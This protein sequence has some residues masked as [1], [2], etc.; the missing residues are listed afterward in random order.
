MEKAPFRRLD[1]QMMKERKAYDAESMVLILLHAELICS[2]GAP[3]IAVQC[4]FL[5]LWDEITHGW[6]S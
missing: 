3:L 4:L 6:G 2:L 5:H 1:D